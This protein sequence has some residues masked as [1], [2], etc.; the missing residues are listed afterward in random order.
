MEEEFKRW[1]T[2]LERALLRVS[3]AEAQIEAFL[4]AHLRL[5][6][7]GRHGYEALLGQAELSADARVVFSSRHRQII[8]LLLPAVAEL[9][10][11][12]RELGLEL[13]SSVLRPAMARV[14]AGKSPVS[15]A[16]RVSRFL[17]GGLRALG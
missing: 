1:R 12:E 9:T 13:V 11:S 2:N 4:L 16:R 10:G 5:V 17:V 14:S 3:G 6:K 7:Q 8:E 15:V